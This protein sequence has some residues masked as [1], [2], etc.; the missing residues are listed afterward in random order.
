M[1]IHV[2]TSINKSST[3]VLKCHKLEIVFVQSACKRKP[4]NSG[5]I[6]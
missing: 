6:A 4:K 3:I 1:T 5:A 2:I